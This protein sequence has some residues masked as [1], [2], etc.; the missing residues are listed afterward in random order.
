MMTLPFLHPFT[1]LLAGPSGEFAIGS[2]PSTIAIFD[3]Q[4]G[5]LFSGAG[6]TQWVRQLLKNLAE[7]VD[8]KPEIIFFCYSEWQDAYQTMEGDVVFHQGIKPVDEMDPL[9][10]KLII[11]DDLMQSSSDEISDVFTKKSHHRNLSAIFLTQNLFQ[12]GKHSRLMSLNSHYICVFKSP[13]DK[14]QIMH[15]AR[16]MYPGESKFLVEAYKD[17]TSESHQYLLI[18]LKQTTPE[19]LRLRAHIFP[20]KDTVVYVRRNQ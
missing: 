20:D 6:K 15:L 10:S 1:M 12:Q 18:D 9:I 8:P 2:I 13:R 17:A 3:T 5:C 19:H 16:T 14:A 11:Y 7:M 4:Y